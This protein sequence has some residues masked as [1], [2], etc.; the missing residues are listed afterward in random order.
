MNVHVSFARLKT[1]DTGVLC[2]SVVRGRTVTP[3]LQL[4]PDDFF[5]GEPKTRVHRH[6]FLLT[7]LHSKT[8]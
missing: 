6:V 7:Q 3:I 8:Q 4:R 5:L 2:M 1:P